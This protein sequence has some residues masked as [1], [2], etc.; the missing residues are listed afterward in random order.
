M[1]AYQEQLFEAKCMNYAGQAEIART[2]TC[3]LRKV[4]QYSATLP[5]LTFAPRYMKNLKATKKNSCRIHPEPSLV[6]M[7]KC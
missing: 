1:R 5:V 6:A 3:D 7:T 2:S 4:K